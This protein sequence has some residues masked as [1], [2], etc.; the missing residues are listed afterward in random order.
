MKCL[1]FVTSNFNRIAKRDVG[2]LIKAGDRFALEN[3]FYFNEDESVVFKSTDKTGSLF[4]KENEK[5][6]S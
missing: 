1:K 5:V 2:S 4:T 6:N 3:G